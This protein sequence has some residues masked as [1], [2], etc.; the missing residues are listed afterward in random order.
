MK[1]F[2]IVNYVTINFSLININLLTLVL[3]LIN[4]N[5]S[6]T[7]EP[8]TGE[9]PDTCGF[10]PSTYGD[11]GLGGVPAL[12]N[13][14]C[15]LDEGFDLCGICGGIAPIFQIKLEP[16]G[17]SD[18]SRIGGSVANWNGTIATS[19][20]INQELPPL[21]NA[22]IIT[23]NRDFIDNSYEMYILPS[24]TGDLINS[25][26][27]VPLGMGY[28]LR[29]SK[30]YLVVGSHDS[31]PRVIQLWFKTNSP[32]WTWSWTANDPC[33]GN[34]FGFSV[35][36]D[37]R[38]PKD[39]DDGLFGTVIA[40]D[41][42]AF[43]S[44]RV[45]IYY[46]YSE[47]ILQTLFYGSGNETEAACFGHSVSADSGYLAVGAP[48]LDYGGQINA[49]S[50][51]IY[52]WNPSSGVQGMYEFRTQITPPLPMENGGF[53][54]SVSVWDCWLMIGDNQRNVYMYKLNSLFVLPL[55]LQQPLGVNLVSRLGYTVSIWDQYAVA[56]DENFIPT[57]T[58]RGTSFVWDRNPLFPLVYRLMYELTDEPTSVNTRYGAEVDVRGGCYVASGITGETPH[59]GVYVTDLCRDDCFGCDNVLNSCLQD[60]LCGVCNGGT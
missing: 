8:C 44:G 3:I 56:G 25:N 6:Q 31:N 39:F 38:V 13:A 52:Q 16:L 43:L 22:P 45:Y 36:I 26:A 17:I 10:L 54:Q 4:I 58:S 28:G 47:G 32:P 21:E 19:Q 15:T 60:D 40:G 50:V 46:T 57:P 49:G 1:F 27:A 30:N 29:M 41:P 14:N 35:A 23:W 12:C 42:G 20:H 37:E 59:G 9:V 5:L 18:L 2:K 51:Y 33:P 48:A 53:G 7:L 24:K 11:L 55:P 34:R